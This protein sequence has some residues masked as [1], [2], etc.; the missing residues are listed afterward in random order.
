MESE[1]RIGHGEDDTLVSAQM[2]RRLA[3]EIPTCKARFVPQ[4]GHLLTENALVIE[5]IRRVLSAKS[6]VRV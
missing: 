1:T 4:A 6:G 5:E 2:A 3:A